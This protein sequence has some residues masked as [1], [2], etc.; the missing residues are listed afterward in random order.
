MRALARR[1]TLLWPA[2]LLVHLVIAGLCLKPGITGDSFNDVTGFYRVWA[3]AARDYGQWP[4]ITQAWVYPVLALVPMLLPLLG[5]HDGYGALWLVLVT[6]LDAAAFALL[7]AQP[8]V[9]RAKAA[10]YWLACIAALGPVA[11]G[12]LDI[13]SVAL[14]VMGV[15]ALATRPA[16]AGVLLALGAWVKFWPAAIVAA[17]VIAVKERWRVLVGA[18]AATAAIVVADAA[19]GGAHQVFSFIGQQAGRGLQIESP[20]ATSLLWAVRAGVPHA[21]IYYDT[22]IYTYQVEGPGAAVLAKAADWGMGLAVA[23]TALL[24]LRAALRKAEPRLAAALLALGFTAAF[25]AFDK[26]GSPQYQSWFAVP[27]M[28]GLLVAA[29]RFRAPAVMVLVMTALSQ[30]IYPWNYGALT[31]AHTWM[32]LVIGVR[33]L[34]EIALFAWALVALWKAGSRRGT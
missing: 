8:T 5:G 9:Q 4:G 2:F 31:G 13:I 3:E 14:A 32:L 29:R 25:C 26:V 22:G 12:R 10:W 16:L 17:L 6:A 18:L 33:N 11:L 21:R 23:A 30:V 19:L 15:V 20:F 1:R 34:L 24:G 28:M 27:V 7:T